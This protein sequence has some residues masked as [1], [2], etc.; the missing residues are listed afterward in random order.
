MP[1]L[2]FEADREGFFGELLHGRGFREGVGDGVGSERPGRPACH[3]GRRRS[4]V[5]R[6]AQPA[7]SG[8]RS[9]PV[10]RPAA[11]LAGRAVGARPLKTHNFITSLHR[12]DSRAPQCCRR[13]GF[14]LHGGRPVCYISSPKQRIRRVQASDCR[15]V[16][17]ILQVRQKLVQNQSQRGETMTRRLVTGALVGAIAAA[18]AGGAAAQAQSKG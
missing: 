16:A 18:F 5:A 8:R 7:D 17:R 1:H 11:R 15:R 12:R 3:C 13:P 9:T 14:S 2:G 10:Q 6:R 4:V